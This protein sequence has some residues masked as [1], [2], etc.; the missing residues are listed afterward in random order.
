MRV[1]GALLVPLVMVEPPLMAALP[2]PFIP[3]DVWAKNRKYE[4]KIF[5]SAFTGNIFT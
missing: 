4:T 1:L 2:P 5:Y 3:Q